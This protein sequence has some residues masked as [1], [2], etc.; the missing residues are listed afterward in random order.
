M[1]KLPRFSPTPEQGAGL[2]EDNLIELTA[3]T[4][5][6]YRQAIRQSRDSINLLINAREVKDDANQ[7]Q[8]IG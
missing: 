1:A 2:D 4:R 6:D 7:A 8:P 3:I 5:A